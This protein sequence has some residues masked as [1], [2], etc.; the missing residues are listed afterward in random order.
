M[1]RLISCIATIDPENCLKLSFQIFTFLAFL[2][3]IYGT[4][5]SWVGN[6]LFLAICG[7][8]IT[9]CS[10]LSYKK[11]ID[12]TVGL[13]I[14]V[15]IIN[16]GLVALAFGLNRLGFETTTNGNYFWVELGA[17]YSE[18]VKN[19]LYWFGVPIAAAVATYFIALV[20]GCVGSILDAII[21]R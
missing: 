13:I 7:L 18:A 11:L 15:G 14:A 4:Y 17:P 1:K 3:G 9:F 20:V 5:S 16:G 21:K 2:A 8:V 10:V 19:N 12:D 6:D